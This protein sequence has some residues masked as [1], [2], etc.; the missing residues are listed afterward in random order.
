MLLA[1]IICI[2]FIIISITI[3]IYPV[4]IINTLRRIFLI[5]E[6]DS[7]SFRALLYRVS[8]IT[9]IIF[10]PYSFFKH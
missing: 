5:K 10:F 8:G 9:G 2:I 4:K 1:Q 7:E 3:T 6:I